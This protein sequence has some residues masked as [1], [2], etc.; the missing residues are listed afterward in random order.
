MVAALLRAVELLH[1]RQCLHRDIAPDNIIIQPNGVPVLLDFGAARRIIGDMTQALTAVLKPSYAPIEQYTEDGGLAQGPW[2]DVY[3]L[4]ATLRMAITGKPPPSSVGRTIKDAL[5][6][7]ADDPPPNFG[8]DLPARHR[9]GPRVAARGPAADDRRV[10]RCDGPRRPTRKARRH[11]PTLGRGAIAAA[12]PT[13][14][15]SPSYGAAG[16]GRRD[17]LAVPSPC[18]ARM[19]RCRRRPFEWTRCRRRRPAK[20]AAPR[21]APQARRHDAHRD[22][23]L[24][25]SASCW[26]SRSWPTGS[27][28][29]RRRPPRRARDGT[30]NGHRLRRLHRGRRPPRQRQRPCRRRRRRHH[31]GATGH[32]RAPRTHARPAF[33][34]V[35][36]CGPLDAHPIQGRQGRQRQQGCGVT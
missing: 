2:T 36:P 35:K 6:K 13:I 29:R 22:R 5:V 31:L 33:G 23:A 17:V 10:S 20:T 1:S 28:R 12:E 18:R 14:R 25:R 11:R 8:S 30:R 16:R 15:L 7:L 27:G 19:P 34:S 32:R 4:A 3:A 21:Q 24:R 9:R 26:S